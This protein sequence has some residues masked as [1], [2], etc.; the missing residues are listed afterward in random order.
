MKWPFVRR[1]K[2]EKSERKLFQQITLLRCEIEHLEDENEELRDKA[3]RYYLDSFPNRMRDAFED[4]RFNGLSIRKAAEKHDLKYTT[5]W[6][7]I[8][9][10][11]KIEGEN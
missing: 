3:V 11:R 1:S 8:D 6:N 10:L 5:F 7:K 9:K 2:V 4:W